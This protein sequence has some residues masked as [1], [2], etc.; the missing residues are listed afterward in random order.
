MLIHHFIAVDRDAQKARVLEQRYQRA[1]RDE[2][3]RVHLPCKVGREECKPLVMDQHFFDERHERAEQQRRRSA[4]PTSTVTVARTMA[5]T[6]ASPKPPSTAMPL[7][8]RW[9]QQPAAL[10]ARQAG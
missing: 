1:R 7:P 2:R 9:W 6:M 10:G 8:S 5:I 4:S 3:E